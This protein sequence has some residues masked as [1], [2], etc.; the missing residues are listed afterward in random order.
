MSLRLEAILFNHDLCSA[1]VDAFNLR[2]NEHDALQLPEWRPGVSTN[3]KDSPTAYAR[4]ETQ[5]N[6]LTI[7]VDFSFDGAGD[8]EIRARDANLHREALNGPDLSQQ[9]VEL[10]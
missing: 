3:P 1:T 2:K 8:R 10:F 9:E 7:K 6:T 4:S 5:G